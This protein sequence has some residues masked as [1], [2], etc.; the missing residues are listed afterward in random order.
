VCD[1]EKTRR[2]CNAY[3]RAEKTWEISAQIGKK[4]K[5]FADI[6]RYGLTAHIK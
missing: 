3:S 1:D 5:K 6:P 4:T 2:V